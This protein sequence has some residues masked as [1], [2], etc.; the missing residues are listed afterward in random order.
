MDTRERLSTD[1]EWRAIFCEV[2]GWQ[3]FASGEARGMV[4]PCEGGLR[5]QFD[6]QGGGGFVAFRREVQGRL[7]AAFSWKFR[8][9]GNVSSQAVEF[10]VC[11]PGGANVWR[12]MAVTTERLCAE[13]KSLTLTEKELAF[14]WGPAGGGSPS[15]V[16]ALEWVA[17]AEGGGPGGAGFFD[18]EMLGFEDESPTQPASVWAS[19]EATG[20]SVQQVHFASAVESASNWEQR[21]NQSAAGWRPSPQE[22]DAWMEADF[23]RGVRCGGVF[24]LWAQGCNPQGFCLEGAMARGAWRVLHEAEVTAKECQPV[25]LP[26][27]EFRFLRL[28]VTGACELRSIEFWPVVA[29]AANS[30]LHAVARRQARGFFPR[31]WLREQSYW[32]PVGLPEGGRRALLEEGGAVEIDEG[33][34]SLEPFLWCGGAWRSWA[35]ATCELALPPGG[36]PLPVVR[37]VGEGW[38]LTVRPHM[39]GTPGQERLLV[40]YAWTCSDP[41]ARLAVA[42]RPWQVVPPWQV[43]RNMGGVAHIEHVHILK[44]GLE[45]DC[46]GG[47]HGALKVEG[48]EVL[49]EP[50]A[51]GRGGLRWAAT[52]GADFLAQAAWDTEAEVKDASGWAT[53]LLWWTSGAGS[54]SVQV[55]VNLAPST[56]RCIA[57]RAAA[58]TRWQE[59]LQGLEGFECLKGENAKN[60]ACHFA[61]DVPAVGSWAEAWRCARTAVGHLL[62]NRAGAALQPGPRRYT[63]SWIR[64][65][66]IMGAA[67]ARAGQPAAL[68]DFV[69]WFAGWVRPDGFVPCVVDETGVDTL[70][71]HDS[72]GQ[73]LWGVREAWWFGAGEDF[74]QEMWPVVERVTEYLR[75]LRERSAEAPCTGL[76]PVSVSHEGYFAQPVHSFWDDFWGVRGV[77]AAAEVAATLG[78]A[79][80]AHA[81]KAEGEDFRHAVATALRQVMDRRRIDYVPGSVEWADFDP[82]A[83][84][85]AV[86]LLDF[87]DDL[88][89]AALTHTFSHYLDGVRR[90]AHTTDWKNYT[91][92]EVR[93][94]GAFVRC[95]RRAE[96]QEL[97]STFLADRR[98]VAWNQWPEISWR[99]PRAPGHLGDLPHA[100]IG[101]EFFLSWWSCL[102][103]ERESTGEI[104]LAAGLRREWLREGIHMARCPVRGGQWRLCLEENANRIF[105]ELQGT[106][107]QMRVIFFPPLAENEIL[108]E[109]SPGVEILEDARSAQIVAW[110]CKA[111][112][113]IAP[114]EHH[115]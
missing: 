10:K 105:L 19:S 101:A 91:A 61:E 64:D 53:A 112:F 58:L 59:A 6:F 92:Y 38:T 28:R 46:D 48:R 86:G 1:G 17:V 40:E 20:F 31:Y 76:L 66:V 49:C 69:R 52:G 15:T 74:L 55:V 68:E 90:R 93:L 16:G 34:F 45:N 56:S 54:H 111:T 43:F 35:D 33:A 114:R 97:L 88:P 8:L 106:V 63:R 83:T 25:F 62:M 50:R 18:V 79:E 21:E 36:E 104:I 84:A 47:F 70:V 41:E 9:R 103:E 65:G 100:W 3:V 5:F 96:A 29:D 67:L 77:M 32:S 24:L 14:A 113:R 12:A 115:P 94:V 7:P 110:P 81:W 39:E 108:E 57:G 109:A 60:G 98:P 13:G 37:R 75:N 42:C 72:H 99:D 30:F 71:E 4:S 2:T 11:D 80:R 85:N 107:P 44:D 27:T 87:A 95:G 51:D 26:G 73:F 23:G 82:T 89:S 78:H 102:I 22:V